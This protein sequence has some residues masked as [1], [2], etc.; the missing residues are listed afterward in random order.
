MEKVLIRSCIRVIIGPLS[1]LSSWDACPLMQPSSVGPS[2]PGK[3]LVRY[4]TPSASEPSFSPLSTTMTSNLNSNF[5]QVYDTLKHDLIHDPLFEFD[6]DYRQRVDRLIDYNVRGGKMV[7]GFSVVD[8]YQL[9]KC[10]QL[11]DDEVFLAST[12]GWCT[13]WLQAFILVHD[14]MMDGSHIRRGHPCWFRLPEVGVA[15]INDGVLLR[16]HVHRILKKYFHLK[17]YYM[18]LVDLFNEVEFLT[19][20]GQMIDVEENDVSKY[21]LSLNRR[22]NMYKGGYY[23]LYLPVVCALL[24]FGENRPDDDVVVKDVLVELGIYYQV[25]NDYL[26]TFG[27][28]NVYGKT[29]TDIEEFKCSWLIAMALELANEEE[30]KILLENYGT[31]DQDKVEKVKELYHT[32]NL[33]G[34]YEDYEKETQEKLTKLIDSHPNKAIQAVLKSCLGKLFKGHK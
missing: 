11:T 5:I 30:R 15:A 31:T 12:L 1:K 16:N 6:N 19:V 9:L 28:P 10:V 20:S 3:I 33:Q 2:L 18:N 22:I 34:A 24:M 13:E 25:Q 27:D 14:D 32:L 8:S 26:D 21:S 7:R 4:Y 29:G 17:P 23:S